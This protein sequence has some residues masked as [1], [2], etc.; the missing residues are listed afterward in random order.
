MS[1]YAI[2]PDYILVLP[3]INDKDLVKKQ[4]RMSLDKDADYNTGIIIKLGANVKKSEDFFWNEGDWVHYRAIV[5]YKVHLNRK[6][7]EDL[8]KENEGYHKILHKD[9]VL[10]AVL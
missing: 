1:N 8:Q 2:H 7:G 9:E 6:R 10:L 5:G 3:D 4:D